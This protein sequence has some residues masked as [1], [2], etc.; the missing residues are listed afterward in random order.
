MGKSAIYLDYEGTFSRLKKLPSDVEV[1]I[2]CHRLFVS[3]W[4]ES[5]KPVM[6]YVL[7]INNVTINFGDG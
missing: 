6:S 3:S 5:E 4:D 2:R 1:L 7:F